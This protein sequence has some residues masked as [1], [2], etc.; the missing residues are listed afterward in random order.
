[1]NCSS[2][3]QRL[4]LTITAISRKTFSELG[5]RKKLSAELLI[6]TCTGFST[7]A[8][9]LKVCGLG[10]KD[11]RAIREKGTWKTKKSAAVPGETL[12]L[13]RWLYSTICC[14]V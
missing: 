8:L 2:D 14:T 9:S 13:S 11:E 6:A 12:V 5:V 1:M 4:Y 10:R 3:A 7:S